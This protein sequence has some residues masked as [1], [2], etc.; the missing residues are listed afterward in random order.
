MWLRQQPVRDVAL[1]L[2]L[3]KQLKTVAVRADEALLTKPEELAQLRSA[4][5]GEISSAIELVSPFLREPMKP[6]VLAIAR[7]VHKKNLVRLVEAFAAALPG[8]VAFAVLDAADLGCPSARKRLIVGDTR[9]IQHLKN[10]PARRTSIREAFDA[11]GGLSVPGGAVALGVGRGAK[12]ASMDVRVMRTF[13]QTA[14][15][16]YAN[17]SAL[18]AENWSGPQ[19][20]T[21][22]QTQASFAIAMRRGEASEAALLNH[23]FHAEIGLMADNAYLVASLNRLLID[24]TR[25]S[26]T[27]Y[28]PTSDAD[29]DRVRLAIEQH[30]AMIAAFERRETALSMDL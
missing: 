23:R 9:T 19:L 11:Y 29:R 28:R 4:A 18:A 5:G 1:R 25:M 15:L 16:V 7:P 30:D 20:E 2:R 24:H 8:R 17:I 22:K 21:L 12:V 26:Q 13:F 27:F 10:E 14:P 3:R 6:V